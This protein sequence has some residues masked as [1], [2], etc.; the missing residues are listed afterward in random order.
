MMNDFWLASSYGLSIADPNAGVIESKTID[1]EGKESKLVMKIEHG[2]RQ[3]S[4]EIFITHLTK[5]LDNWIRVPGEGNLEE[6]NFVN[7]SLYDCDYV[8]HLANELDKLEG[9]SKEFSQLVSDDASVLDDIR[10]LSEF[11]D[12]DAGRFTYPG[13]RGTL[14][15]FD[16]LRMRP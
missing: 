5:D 6:I 12:C 14:L 13:K 4:S 8:I 16:S 9:S 2:I 3:A 1:H 15:V 7:E 10:T 11:S